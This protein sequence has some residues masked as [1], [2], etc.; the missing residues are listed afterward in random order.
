MKKGF[1]LIE[2]LVVVLIIGI[3]SAIAIPLYKK[4]IEK[5]RAAEALSILKPLA[6]S[7]Q[8]TE[9]MRGVITGGA[10]NPWQYVDILP[11]G[12]QQSDT[13]YQT[14]NF[15]YFLKNDGTGTYISEERRTG[16][17]AL[18]KHIHSG[19]ILP[20]VCVYTGTAGEQICRSLGFTKIEAHKGGAGNALTF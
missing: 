15:N 11:D 3:L 2:L 7:V 6:E 10:G 1:T 14:K 8:R 16:E 4:S 20:T 18:E 17:Y 9:K 12:V 13:S 19:D 5:G